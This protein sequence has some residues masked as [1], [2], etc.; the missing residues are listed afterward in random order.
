[1]KTIT[2]L[3]ATAAAV[4]CLHTSGALAG[5][6]G[7]APR[8][9]TAKP[10]AR[11]TGFPNGL[12][13][14]PGDPGDDDT[15]VSL[16][17]SLSALCQSFIGQLNNY[18][19]PFPNVDQINHD[20]IVAAGTQLGC[21]TAQNETT[22]AVNPWNPRNLVAGTNDY[23][24]FNTREGRDDGAGFAYTTTDGGRTWKDVQLPHLTFQT[25]ATGALSDMDS[26]GDPSVA[27]GP[28]GTVY[29][30]HVVFSR[31]NNGG[32]IVVSASH[33]GGHTWG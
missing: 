2:V 21:D 26:A 16:A 33:D 18:R 5:P 22:I 6:T 15:A 13:S 14:H 30:S 4:C 24:I 17:P 7:K 31:L 20:A 29:F 25:G 8:M 23:R 32:G 28:D 3:A 12:L 10:L 1:M 9:L 27:F 11:A 19:N